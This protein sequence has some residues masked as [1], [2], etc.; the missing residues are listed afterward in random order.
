MLICPKCHKQLNKINNSYVCI[1]NHCFDISRYGYVNLLLSKT[2]SGDNKEMV[3]ARYN[4]LTKNYYLKLAIFINNLLFN[5][6]DKDDIVLDG[7]CGIGFYDSVLKIDHPNIIGFDISKEA[8]I[9]ATK[10]NKNLMY[11]VA[12]GASIPLQEKTVSCILNIF[13]PTFI[14]ESFRILKDDGLLIVIT[15]GAN[16]L[17]EL[18]KIIYDKAYL[19][20]EKVPEFSGFNLI[21]QEELSYIMKLNND[22]LSN[23]IKMTPYFYKT[24]ISDLNKINNLN[25]LEVSASFNVLVYKK[26]QTI[27]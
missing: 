4:F 5:Y 18:K 13:A 1:N 2:S 24:N 9:K 20:N 21:K 7:G 6:L 26:E 23:L 12:S 17:I 8:I 15:P 25:S 10:L 16:H 22:D 3:M 19:N 11:F 14:E 27:N